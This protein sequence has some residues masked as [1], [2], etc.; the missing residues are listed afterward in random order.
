MQEIEDHVQEV[1]KKI[2]ETDLLFE[3]SSEDELMNEHL[4]VSE[5]EHGCEHGDW[6][7]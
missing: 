3:D 1:M 5:F 2:E 7:W 6:A 4:E